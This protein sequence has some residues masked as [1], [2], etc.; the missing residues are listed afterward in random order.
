[1]DDSRPMQDT[2]ESDLDL[3]ITDLPPPGEAGGYGFSRLSAA[4]LG[5]QRA[6]YR[7]RRLWRLGGIVSTALLGLVV[8]L[9]IFNPI[10]SNL[11]PHP[12]PAPQKIADTAQD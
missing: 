7:R 2:T 11:V 12:Q 3:K 6:I 9:L 4:V 10:Y 5:L 8:A 1:M